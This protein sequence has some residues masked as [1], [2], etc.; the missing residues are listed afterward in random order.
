MR[1][2]NA[3]RLMIAIRQL[4][5]K[6]KMDEIKLGNEYKDVISGFVGIAVAKTEW[7]N[8]CNRVTLSPKLDKDGK[9]QDSCCFDVEQ[10]EATGNA[11]DIKPKDVGG[12][13]EVPKREPA[14]RAVG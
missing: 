9:I 6:D 2:L 1:I 4:R 11:V 8:G 5:E 12:E 7:I 14:V 10:L 3:L 13:R